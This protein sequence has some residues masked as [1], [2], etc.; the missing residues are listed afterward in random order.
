MVYSGI[1]NR[2][3]LGRWN[4]QFWTMNALTWKQRKVFRSGT[5]E[6]RNTYRKVKNNMHRS[7]IRWL[8]VK[9]GWLRLLVVFPRSGDP[10]V[11]HLLFWDA[12]QTWRLRRPLPISLPPTLTTTTHTRTPLTHTWTHPPHIFTLTIFLELIWTK[13]VCFS[14]PRPLWP[15]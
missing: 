9:G 11:S 4:G 15:E 1:R 6:Q 2:F 14:L 8:V 10:F 7:K 13:L 3:G 12:I 5:E